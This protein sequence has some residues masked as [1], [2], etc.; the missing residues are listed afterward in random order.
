MTGA[1]IKAASRSC[2]EPYFCLQPLIASMEELVGHFDL[3]QAGEEVHAYSNR[4][5][6]ITIQHC[7]IAYFSIPHNITIHHCTIYC[8]HKATE[9]PP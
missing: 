8:P 3:G 4:T 9:Y 5:H 2:D 1:L 6:N 7:I